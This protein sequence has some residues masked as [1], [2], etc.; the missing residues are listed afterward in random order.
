MGKRFGH[1][2]IRLL[3]L[4]PR[5]VGHLDDRIA[6]PPRVLA[7][8]GAVLAV[9]VVVGTDNVIHPQFLSH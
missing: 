8:L 6:R 2:Q 4:E 5:D 1:P 9:Q 3:E 7:F